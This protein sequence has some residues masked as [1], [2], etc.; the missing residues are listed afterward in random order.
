M[1]ETQYVDQL[2]RCGRH[3]SR[4]GCGLWVGTVGR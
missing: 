3:L 2:G 4:N 1:L